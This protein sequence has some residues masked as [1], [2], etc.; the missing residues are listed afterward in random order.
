MAPECAQG[1]V[2]VPSRGD[3]YFREARSR[4]PDHENCSRSGA[5]MSSTILAC[6]GVRSS[7]QP[8][9]VALRYNLPAPFSFSEIFS[10]EC[11]PTTRASLRSSTGIASAAQR[12]RIVLN[13]SALRSSYLSKTL[14]P[15]WE[16]KALLPLLICLTYCLDNTLRYLSMFLSE[17]RSLRAH[18]SSPSYIH[19]S[20]L[21]ASRTDATKSLGSLT[22]STIRLSGSASI[23]RGAPTAPPGSFTIRYRSGVIDGCEAHAVCSTKFLNALVHASRVGSP[24]T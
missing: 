18:S 12:C 21:T 22:S 15:S 20:F 7:R 8:P 5:V 11:F 9:E 23:S 14:R 10:Q 24:S 3:S 4:L 2:I 6:S 1:V 16:S 19:P 17:E 13:V